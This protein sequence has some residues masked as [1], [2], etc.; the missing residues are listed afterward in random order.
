[1][2]KSRSNAFPT[3]SI[4]SNC[5]ADVLSALAVVDY[6]ESLRTERGLD[7]ARAAFPMVELQGEQS[8]H[9]CCASNGG[10]KR[11]GEKKYNG[12]ERILSQYPPRGTEKPS[13]Q[14]FSA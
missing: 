1:M 6:G 12:L 11:K 8:K 4:N 5:N 9:S 2:I 7:R 3:L 10:Q 13:F 14:P